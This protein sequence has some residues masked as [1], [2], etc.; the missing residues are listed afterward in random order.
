MT[1]STPDPETLDPEAGKEGLERFLPAVSWLREYRPKLAVQDGIAGAVLALLLL[2]QALA[3]ALLA[4][5]P[6]EVGLFASVVPALAYA[7][8]GTSRFIAVGPVAL[9]AL[10][11]AD[12]ISRNTGEGTAATQAAVLLA[13]M[14]GTMLVAGGWAGL[15]GLGEFASRPVLDGF[16]AAV[17]MLIASSQIG[18]LVG[19]EIP[20]GAGFFGRFAALFS[21]YPHWPTVWV[22]VACLVLL[23]GLP[24]AIERLLARFGVGEALGS[25]VARSVPFVVLGASMLATAGLEL[26]EHGV[27]TVGTVEVGLPPL[28]L[29]S[30][31]LSLLVDLMP[32]AATLAL[33]IFVVGLAIAQTAKEK[34]EKIDPGRE[35]VALGFANLGS[36]LT[37][38]L[39]VGASVSRSSVVRGAGARTPLAVPVAGIAALA[40]G[41]LAAHLL[42]LLPRAAMAALILSAI[43]GMVDLRQIRLTWKLDRHDGAVLALTF[44]TVLVFGVEVGLGLGVLLSLILHLWQTAHPEVV[45]IGLSEEGGGARGARRSDVGKGFRTPVLVLRI[46]QQLYFGNARWVRQRIVEEV[47][48][49]EC[50]EDL[51]CVLFDLRSVDDIDTTALEVFEELLQDLATADVEYALAETKQPV[52]QKLETRIPGL[53]EREDCLFVDLES[54]LETLEER[55]RDDPS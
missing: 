6:P 5:L 32:S 51:R 38:G 4:E 53:A 29:P 54:A 23:L 34:G 30:G 35:M 2:P 44:L 14:A 1:T 12:A 25:I 52:L 24:P 22:G 50:R 37:G 9:V 46:D 45:V 47:L 26:A 55:Y 20:R 31:S 18:H 48:S 33:V 49:D 21:A 8:F 3:Y 28:T 15:A 42:A 17:A 19:T 16:A 7:A 43:F 40:M 39:P 36:S 13:A 10:L 41:F 27:A 11:T